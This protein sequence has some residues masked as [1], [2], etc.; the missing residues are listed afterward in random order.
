MIK[1][2]ILF[3]LLLAMYS[4]ISRLSRPAISGILLTYDNQPI[5]GGRVG[6]GETDSQGRF[7]ISEKRY[8]KFFLS[9]LMVMEAPPLHVY[10][11]IVFEGYEKDA[12]RL[13]N[14]RGGGQRKGSIYSIDT[15][16]VKRVNEV[17]DVKAMLLKEVWQMSYTQNADTIYLVGKEFT[18]FCKTE[19]CQ[20]FY[21][22]Y[23]AL[24]ENYA[25]SNR[26]NL[27]PEVLKRRIHAE[28]HADQSVKIHQEI[29]FKTNFN[30]PHKPS[31]N[32]EINFQWKVNQPNQ[33]QF[34]DSSDATLNGDYT[35]NSIDKHQIRLIKAL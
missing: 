14:S 19:N 27:P 32:Q 23:Y 20:N 1:Y 34:L 13:F 17:F 33:L 10:E 22:D 9:E 3:I 16:Y 24:T 21:N 15:I 29:H 11:P 28:F 31:Q 30:D 2:T 35:I 26:K 18:P 5:E 12:I 7:F 25:S 6:E 8:T 4:C